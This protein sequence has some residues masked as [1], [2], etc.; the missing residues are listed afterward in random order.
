[1]R[2]L[3]R[4]AVNETISQ[5]QRETLHG[6]GLTV[7]HD[8]SVGESQA[9]N[10]PYLQLLSDRILMFIEQ[11]WPRCTT[12]GTLPRFFFTS[13]RFKLIKIVNG[14][15]GNHGSFASKGLAWIWALPENGCFGA[16]W[17]G[18]WRCGVL[19]PRVAPHGPRIGRSIYCMVKYETLWRYRF[20]PLGARHWGNAVIGT[21]TWLNVGY[22]TSISCRDDVVCEGSRRWKQVDRWYF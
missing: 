10:N 9:V 4:E 15:K 14:C 11:I 1:M 7:H 13:P 6:S 21:T 16:L 2:I 3:Q 18:E 20:T 12:L 19:Q 8:L 17:Y 5:Q 22:H